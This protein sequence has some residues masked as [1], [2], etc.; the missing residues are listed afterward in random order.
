MRRNT[1]HLRALRLVA[2]EAD[3]GLRG[4]AQHLL[5]RRVNVVAVG[6]RDATALVLTAR[7]IRS[8]KHFGFMARETYR[9]PLFG[10]RCR[11]RL[12]F[13]DDVGR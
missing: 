5:I 3:I 2:P 8:R 9:A 12:A 6:A 7:P 4:L 13:K 10:M 1:T 11:L